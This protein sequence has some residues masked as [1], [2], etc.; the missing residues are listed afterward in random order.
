MTTGDDSVRKRFPGRPPRIKL[1]AHIRPFYF[2]T[3]NTA[4][5]KRILDNLSLHQGFIDYA[6]RGYHSYGV[7]VGRYM[8]LPDHIHLFVVL[9]ESGPVLQTWVKGLKALLG[10]VLIEQGFSRPHWQPGFFDHVLRS[11]ESYGEKW[12][13]VSMNPVRAR[14]CNKPEDWPWQGEVARLRF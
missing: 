2:V 14:L 12:Q 8:I 10:R 5:R 9:P 3:F 11:A 13:Y 4:D 1:F 6:T 7:A